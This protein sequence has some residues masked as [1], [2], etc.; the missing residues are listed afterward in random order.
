M[1]YGEGAGFV[2]DDDVEMGETL[3]RFAAFEEDAELRAAANG[4]GERGRNGQA[5]GAGASDDEH[6]DGIGEGELE[7]NGQRRSSRRT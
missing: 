7:A 3:E 1:A 2:E 6:G 4:Y 5:H